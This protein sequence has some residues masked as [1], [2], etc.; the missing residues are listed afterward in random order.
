MDQIAAMTTT[1]KF[2]YFLEQQ[3]TNKYVYNGIT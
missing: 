2:P 3:N 1:H